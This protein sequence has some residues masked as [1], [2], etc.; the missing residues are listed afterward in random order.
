MKNLNLMKELKKTIHIKVPRDE[1]YNA[2]TN[3]LTI[4]LWSGYKA[5]FEN[6]PGTEFSIFDG[7][8]TGTIK[9]LESPSRYKA[10]F[11]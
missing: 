7:D 5:V 3:S 1:V 9:N 11:Y 8:I 2:I 4:E 6:K 10:F